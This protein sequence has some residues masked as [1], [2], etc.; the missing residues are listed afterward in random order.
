[1]GKFFH[2]FPYQ[3]PIE[4]R[5]VIAVRR[6]V[7]KPFCLEERAGLAE[8]ASSCKR[9]LSCRVIYTQ[10]ATCLHM[11]SRP[12]HLTEISPEAD[13]ILSSQDVNFPCKAMQVSQPV[14]LDKSINIVH[15][16]QIASFLTMDYMLTHV[17][18]SSW[19]DSITPLWRWAIKQL[20]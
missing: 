19:L 4:Y 14:H 5:D 11:W 20:S 18:E 10:K 7:N 15:I 2:C 6:G 8:L 13:E 1:M 17:F 3:V 16:Q 9:D 12:A